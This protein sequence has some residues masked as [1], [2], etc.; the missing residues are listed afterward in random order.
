[1]RKKIIPY[2]KSKWK[3]FDNFNRNKAAEV[4]EEELK[5]LQNIFAVLLNGQMLG[6]PS[7]PPYISF[8]LL[9]HME[10]DLK[11]MFEKMETAYDPLAT[12]FSNFDIG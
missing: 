3:A 9:P 6:L 2:F 7:P 8:E 4:H 12:L 11:I 1:M 5:E 10:Q